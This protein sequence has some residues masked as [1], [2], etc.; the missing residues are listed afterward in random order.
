MTSARG[1]RQPCGQCS[2]T[3]SGSA[4]ASSSAGALLLR[5]VGGGLGLF[6]RR[7][8]VRA[9]IEHRVK[10]DAEADERDAGEDAKDDGGGSSLFRTRSLKT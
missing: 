6:G 5:R 4:S 7:A 9:A 3:R 2:P 10:V 1:L 8:K